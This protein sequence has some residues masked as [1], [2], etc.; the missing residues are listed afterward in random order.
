MINPYTILR[1]LL[2]ALLLFSSGGSAAIPRVNTSPI[3]IDPLIEGKTYSFNLQLDEPIICASGSTDCYVLYYLDNPEPNLIEIDPCWIRWDVYDWTDI[4]QFTIRGI[5]H[6][7]NV[8]QREF[9]IKPR[10]IVSKSDYYSGFQPSSITIRTKPVPTSTC[11]STGDP[12]YTTFDGYYFHF[13]G[14]GKEWLVNGVSSGLAIQTVTH[15]SGYSRNCAI[16][17]LENGN[18][19]MVS[20]C[21]GYIEFVNRPLNPDVATQPKITTS[22]GG[23]NYDIRYPSGVAL[24]FQ[25]WGDNANVYV[26]LPGTYYQAGLTGLCGN[27]DGNAGNEGLAYVTWE[28]QNLP[29]HLQVSSQDDLFSITDAKI[30][31]TLKPTIPVNTNTQGKCAYVPPIYIRPILNN[32]DVEDITEIIKQILIKPP[33]VDTDFVLK[34]EDQVLFDLHEDDIPV[35]LTP[36]V[37]Q[38]AAM[39]AELEDECRAFSSRPELRACSQ[40][41]VTQGVA[42]CLADIK[43]FAD[44]TV[45]NQNWQGVITLCNNQAALNVTPADPSP[46]AANQALLAIVITNPCANVVCGYY[47]VCNA[48]GQCVCADPNMRG[49]RCDIPK[50]AQVEVQL[51]RPVMVQVPQNR[52]NPES[53]SYPIVF[54]V[55]NLDPT[56][57]T[58]ECL[59][60]TSSAPIATIPATI[61]SDTLISC[62]AQLGSLVQ[63]A[64]AKYAIP[65]QWNLRVNGKPLANI[66]GGWT[67]IYYWNPCFQCTVSTTDRSEY[68][69]SALGTCFPLG[70]QV[71]KLNNSADIAAAVKTLADDA[72]QCVAAGAAIP[73][74][75]CMLCRN[76]S[77]SFVAG[78]LADGE[79]MP[80]LA[81]RDYQFNIYEDDI[82]LQAAIGYTVSSRLFDKWGSLANIAQNQLSVGLLGERVYSIGNVSVG[83]SLAGCGIG[84]DCKLQL[85]VNITRLDSPTNI[86]VVM[87]LYYGTGVLD[88][89]SPR[90]T[91]WPSFKTSTTTRTVTTA[92]ISSDPTTT[93]VSTASTITVTPIIETTQSTTRCPVIVCEYPCVRITSTVTGCLLQCIC[94][95]DNPEDEQDHEPAPEDSFSSTSDI[96][97]TVVTTT[98]QKPDNDSRPVVATGKTESNKISTPIIIVFVIG[99]V[100]AFAIMVLFA[101]RARNKPLKDIGPD[102]LPTTMDPAMD[103]QN[104]PI[105]RGVAASSGSVYGVSNPTYSTYK[106]NPLYGSS[107]IGPVN[108]TR[109]ELATTNPTYV[110]GEY[111]QEQSSPLNNP[112]YSVMGYQPGEKLAEEIYEGCI[113]TGYNNKNIKNTEVIGEGSEV[114]G[115]NEGSEVIGYNEGSEVEYCSGSNA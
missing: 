112:M 42:A 12:H 19:V 99:S 3:R 37:N 36:P 88:F 69:H 43:L 109:S 111:L 72:L 81:V 77:T 41:T 28:L 110:T 25:T 35:V 8:P 74:N 83:S 108:M 24:S 21:R 31:A 4:R 15:G 102:V 66:N 97:T 23:S 76:H 107:P 91:L 10:A 1:N 16:A 2:L 65:V 106:P 33:T 11:S 82:R 56:Q 51:Y 59:I 49:P 103:I 52:P 68:C 34:P 7:Y 67:Q 17:A 22:G 47:A 114:I 26:T 18:Y 78:A 104:N 62:S 85:L 14:R 60:T 93:Q 101:I 73:E 79:C 92:S 53:V 71:L 32:P 100:V 9:T 115:H 50:N 64:L 80:K 27:W 30:L 98:T 86:P 70:A 38:T 6:Y 63:P 44:I 29:A 87:A 58:V 40:L 54:E 90:I 95:H 113:S 55:A 48:T 94:P 20:V 46:A 84:Q 13:Y 61:L 45:V 39:I 105:F 5:P 96:I 57:D 75:P 89:V